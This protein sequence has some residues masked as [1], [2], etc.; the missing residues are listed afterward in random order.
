MSGSAHRLPYLVANF[1]ADTGWRVPPTPQIAARMQVALAFFEKHGLNA[2]PLDA[3]D[4]GYKSHGFNPFQVT[5]RAAGGKPTTVTAAMQ[6]IDFHFDVRAV[7]LPPATQLVAFRH[8][9][10]KRGAPAAGRWY[11]RPETPASQLALPPDQTA[12]H[13]Y[14]VQTQTPALESIAGDLLVDWQMP[15]SLARKPTAGMDYHYRKGGGVQYL[16]PHA[17]D[18]LRP[19]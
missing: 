17:K 8:Q 9:G 16:V 19:L 6:A 4:A 12:R 15:A 10:F 11:T 14:T 2:L 18:D 1:L 7:L 3:V 13:G 5:S